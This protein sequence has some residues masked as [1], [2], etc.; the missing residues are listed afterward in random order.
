M[1]G[2]DRADGGQGKTARRAL[3][4]VAVV[5]LAL[6]LWQ[7][8]DALLLLFIGVLL[9]VFLRGLARRLSTH[10]PLSTKWSLAVVVLAIAGLIA[11]T[12]VLLGP[13]ISQQ[14]AQLSQALPET[15]DQLKQSL[16]QTEWGR[17]VLGEVPTSGSELSRRG[18]LF[19]RLTGMASRV[20]SIVTNAILILFAAV[21]FAADPD[22]YKRGL[23]LLVPEHK[24]G[25]V[26]QALDASG[27][28]LWKWLMGKF[29]AMIFVGVFVT[30]GLLLLGVPLAL[31]L[32]VIAGL[33]DFVPFVGP[34]AAAV[35]AILLAFTVSP[36]KALYA[37]LV[38]FV[39]Q[40]IE[41]NVIT[42]LIQQKEVSLPPVLV[43]FAVIAAGLVFGLLGI[44]VATPLVVVIMVVV[45]M[46]Y[47]EDALGKSV[48]VPG[49]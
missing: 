1:N 18:N 22:L 9:A 42:P 19:S 24:T 3:T 4:V 5:G 33:L 30:V 6:L 11:G 27:R 29:V 49:Q 17:Y 31:A 37:G 41:G 26:R 48:S 7:I 20:M 45:K 8:V 43:L 38:Y 25:R 21:F 10:A 16:Q 12:S 14:F 13:R 35:P 47:V 15:V 32:G 23:V 34:I 44:I 2:T 46:L 36:A 28:A 39:A 40:Q